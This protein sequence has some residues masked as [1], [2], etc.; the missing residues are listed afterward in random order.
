MLRLRQ[1]ALVAEKRDPVVDGLK[2]VF[3]VEVAFNDPGVDVFGL[4][5]AVIPFNQQFVEVVAPIREDTA[6][7]RYLARRKGDGGYM[8]ILQCDDHPARKARV[9]ELGIR[10]VAEADEKHYSIMQLHP[11]D[12]K[13]SFLEIDVQDGGEDLDGPWMP[14]GKTWQQAKRTERVAGIAAAEIQ[15]PEPHVVAE[16]WS[17]ILDL[18]L[19]D[20]DG[21]PTLELD[22]ATIRFVP[23]ADGRGEGL[24]GIDI[25]AAD[26]DAI[27]AAA[28]ERGVKGDDDVIL[29]GG[30]RFRLV[31]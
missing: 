4:E 9:D 22:N 5:N 6:G 7:G 19:G 28:A 1:L 3:G 8:V 31:D 29:L 25:V 27:L 15:S 14:A 18:T 10:K 12:T 13:G 2:D 24:G 30:I 26:K 21:T 17:K 11:Q 20:D 16:R 23:D